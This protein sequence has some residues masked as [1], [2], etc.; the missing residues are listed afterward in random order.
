MQNPLL[1]I[2]HLKAVVIL[3][4]ALSYTRAARRLGISQPGLTRRIQDAERRLDRRLFQRNNAHVELRSLC[5][6]SASLA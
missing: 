4:E 3:A 2:R 1:E 5:I 6:S